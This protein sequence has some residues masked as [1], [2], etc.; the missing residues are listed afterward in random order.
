MINNLQCLILI[1]PHLA[2]L[3]HALNSYHGESYEVDEG[4]GLGLTREM[5]VTIY[6]I[7]KYTNTGY[8]RLSLRLS[9]M[10]SRAQGYCR[11]AGVHRFRNKET[12][13]VLVVLI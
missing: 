2:R 6:L 8:P 4:C 13:A 7:R 12:R 1:L 10:V 11:A 3:G 5:Q 9:L